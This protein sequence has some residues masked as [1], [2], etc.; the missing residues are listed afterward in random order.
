MDEE[1]KSED[2]RPADG[3]TP[4][5]NL[6]ALSQPSNNGDSTII[7]DDEQHTPTG[8]H[9]L[10]LGQE[11]EEPHS[12]YPVPGSVN[13][14]S[15]SPALTSPSSNEAPQDQANTNNVPT[16]ETHKAESSQINVVPN[17]LPE[18]ASLE[19]APFNLSASN[20]TGFHQ[21]VPYIQPPP[22]PFFP[23]ASAQGS[24][25]RPLHPPLQPFFMPPPNALLPPQ[26]F[27]PFPMNY[28]PNGLQYAPGAARPIPYSPI[29]DPL[30]VSSEWKEYTDPKTGNPYYVHRKTMKKQWK[31][32][33]G[34]LTKKELLRPVCA[35]IIGKSEW[36]VVT[37]LGGRDY[38]YNTLTKTTSWELPSD[39]NTPILHPS[40]D[41]D[42][43][44]STEQEEGTS[45][46]TKRT[47]TQHD[48]DGQSKRAKTAE[49][50]ETNKEVSVEQQKEFVI[51]FPEDVVPQNEDEF[52]RRTR[53]F[54]RLLREKNVGPDSVWHD[55]S[56][57]LAQDERYHSIVSRAERM[58][59]FE[60]FVR[61][62]QAEIKAEKKE[63]I[64][65]AKTQFLELVDEQANKISYK[66]TFSEFKDLLRHDPRYAELRRVDPDQ[67][68]VAY[69]RTIG[70]LEEAHRKRRRKFKLEFL[71]ML[72]EKLHAEI[73]RN[74]RLRWEE[75][76]LLLEDDPRYNRDN[77]SS[78]DRHQLFRHFFED[79]MDEYEK[80][81]KEERKKKEALRSLQAE[82]RR[83]QLREARYRNKEKEKFILQE[84]VDNISSLYSEC[85]SR[86]VQWE[87][88]LH[89]FEADYRFN[90]QFLT[91]Q[92]KKK[93]FEDHLDSIRKK[94]KNAFTRLVEETGCGFIFKEWEEISQEIVKD[95]RF[96]SVEDGKKAFEDIKKSKLEKIQTDLVKSFKSIPSITK[97]TD[98]ADR[99]TYDHIHLSLRRDPT[100][101][102][103][104]NDNKKW[105][106]FREEL[107]KD[108]IE[109]LQMPC[110]EGE[111]IRDNAEGND[112]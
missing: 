30:Q 25:D 37:T 52:D 20:S 2:E 29:V 18:Q 72:E 76:K 33:E 36:K 39:F 91:S 49:G 58:S 28:Y 54:K 90:T 43:E 101:C 100:W 21:S 65:S 102:Y 98:L 71:D 106:Y 1:A 62:R 59:I 40:D 79:V 42:E 74:N 73:L 61:T 47:E 83:N 56:S 89:L 26:N 6:A 60:S 95:P 31:R 45:S 99:S 82:A 88:V 13:T 112:D 5:S 84:E 44:Q 24:R 15:S 94:K 110:D 4:A 92:D 103:M 86:E 93:M 12:D 32:P 8:T 7:K 57:E 27:N 104:S 23:M 46:R 75:A 80:K 64:E 55:F 48:D 41:E 108:Y 63:K 10:E 69:D 111:K 105:C 17:C 66:T 53:L 70:E 34:F 87:D 77:L 109:L 50:D 3:T 78:E 81:L 22:F 51:E 19:P 11:S 67:I 96:R 16:S 9:E 68:G 35:K 38:F 107:L 85:V 97:D 14:A